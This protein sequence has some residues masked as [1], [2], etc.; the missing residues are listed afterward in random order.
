MNRTLRGV[1]YETLCPS[2]T[3][4]A[5]DIDRETSETRRV[6]RLLTNAEEYWFHDIPRYRA[7]LA[8]IKARLN[9]LAIRLQRHVAHCNQGCKR[10]TDGA[11]FAASAERSMYDRAPHRLK[12]ELPG[13]TALAAMLQQ[14]QTVEGLGA[15]Y[16]RHPGTIRARIVSAGYSSTTGLPLQSQRARDDDEA[17]P[18]LPF[19]E[20]PPWVDDALCAQT[21]PEAFFPER[22]GSTK[23]AKRTCMACE[24]REQ[25]LQA[26]LDRGELHGVWGGKSDRERRQIARAQRN[27]KEAS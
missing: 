24:V 23:A 15:V 27:M 8:Q 9:D 19:L 26:A 21:D 3:R 4:H 25:C 22:G 18:R 7:E 11:A 1:T 13:A 14:G 12:P 20:V 17:T 6:A 10:A 5:D 2:G 16:E